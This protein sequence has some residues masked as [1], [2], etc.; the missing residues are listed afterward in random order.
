MSEKYKMRFFNRVIYISD[1]LEDGLTNNRRKHNIKSPNGCIAR[2][3]EFMEP[4]FKMKY[5]IKGGLQYIVYGRFA[6][7]KLLSLIRK[8]KHK[9]LA[10]MC[11]PAGLLL[12]YQWKKTQ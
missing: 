6:G 10:T 4:N 2:A 8:S 11:M 3:E 1:Y 12:H 7:F 5:R 9:V